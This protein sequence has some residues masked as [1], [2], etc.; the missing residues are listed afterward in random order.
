MAP[1]IR[2]GGLVLS[3]AASGCSLVGLG[4][5][6]STPKWETRHLQADGSLDVSHVADG[7]TVEVIRRDA[8]IVDGRFRGLSGD[9]VHVERSDGYD[10]TIMKR[11]F[12]R[13]RY[14]RGS[15]WAAGLVIGLAA[16]LL[17][18]SAI[19]VSQLSCGRCG[20]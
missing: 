8:G 9:V 13:I 6:A 12:D 2:M 3:L 1:V 10:L 16:D 14:E 11:D 17:V 7:D 19:A 20:G 18:G 4:I 15:Y 5:G